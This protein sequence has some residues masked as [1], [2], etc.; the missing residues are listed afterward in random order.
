[1]YASES[2]QSAWCFMVQIAHYHDQYIWVISA[3]AMHKSVVHP[4][5]GINGCKKIT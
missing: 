4:A 5:T 1:M 3:Y 2:V